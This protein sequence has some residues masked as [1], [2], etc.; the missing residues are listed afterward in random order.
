MGVG[1][2][3]RCF[4]LNETQP[5]KSSPTAPMH[6]K[7]GCSRTLLSAQ[8]KG[9]SVLSG[10]ALEVTFCTSYLILSSN[11]HVTAKETSAES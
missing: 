11:P 5:L 7:Q 2:P 4:P 8:Q 10:Q 1:G 9:V 6:L 3:G